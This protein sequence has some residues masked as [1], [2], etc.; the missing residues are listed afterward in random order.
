[1]EGPT[2]EQG[3]CSRKL[4]GGS[5]SDHEVAIRDVVILGVVP[6]PIRDLLA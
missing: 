5:V 6:L 2:H 4:Q 1:M 3:S